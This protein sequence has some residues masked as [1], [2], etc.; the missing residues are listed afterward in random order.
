MFT[1]NTETPDEFVAECRR[2]GQKYF[3]LCCGERWSS[4]A[5]GK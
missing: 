2:L 5:L 1:F 4:E 3:V